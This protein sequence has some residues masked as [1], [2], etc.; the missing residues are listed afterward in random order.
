MM[1]HNTTS[2]SPTQEIHGASSAWPCWFPSAH[3]AKSDSHLVSQPGD[4]LPPWRRPL[5]DALNGNERSDQAHLYASL[6][7]IKAF[8]RPSNRSVFFRGF[9]SDA[10]EHTT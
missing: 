10:I 4:H 6:A 1:Q 7:T 8:G 9:L 3:G 2:V 5:E